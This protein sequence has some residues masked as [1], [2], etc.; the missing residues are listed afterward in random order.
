[1]N[2]WLCLLLGV[3]IVALLTMVARRKSDRRKS[4]GS[5]ESS[6]GAQISGEYL[7]SQKPKWD[8]G[9][10]GDGDGGGGD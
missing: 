2:L 4:D 8:D 9:G 10:D 7:P 6:S 3:V 5:G 1:M